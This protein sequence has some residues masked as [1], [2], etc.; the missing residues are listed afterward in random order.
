MTSRAAA[1]LL[2]ACAPC[3]LAACFQE[4]DTG[5]ATDPQG[6]SGG[7]AEASVSEPD[8]AASA[9]GL[10]PWQICQCPSCDEANGTIPFMQQTPAIYLPDGGA[11]NDPCVDVEALSV[12]IRQ[13]YCAGCHGPGTGAGQGGFNYVLDDP[14]LVGGVT[15]NATFP[16]FVVSGDPSH[17]YLYVSIAS[18]QMPPPS[19]AGAPPN[20]VP[21][22]ADLSVLYGWIVAC[23]PG[24]DAGYVTGGGSYG[25]ASPTSDGGAG[26]DASG[27]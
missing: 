3:A 11:T 10:T 19:M 5:A 27:D 26:G 14:S 4:L 25:P 9:A 2:L 7:G 22:A 20:P 24:P 17:S 21:T 16:H 18:G 6:G 13:K 23:F 1:L 12:S 15:S 8:D